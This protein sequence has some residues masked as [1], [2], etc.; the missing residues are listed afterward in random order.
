M[1]KASERKIIQGALELQEKIAIDIM[2]PI[3]KVFMLE[4]STKL[5]YPTLREIYAKGFSRIPIYERTRDNI[6][7]I[8]MARDLILVN[9]DKAM[10]SLKQL[11]SIIIRDVVVVD[12]VDKVEPLLTHFKKGLT[13]IG[14]VTKIV[15]G[16]IGKDPHRQVIGIVTMEDIIEE[17]I[18]DKIED[19]YEIDV[20]NERKLLKEKL[21]LFYTDHQ[22]AK[23]LAGSEIK[24][25]LQFLEHYV[26][27]FQAPHMKRDILHVLIRRSKVV[28]VT[29]DS[30]PFSH[31]MLQ[32]EEINKPR[33]RVINNPG[34]DHYERSKRLQQLKKLKESGKAGA[35][36]DEEAGRTDGAQGE[37]DE[38]K[39]PAT[40]LKMLAES[41]LI[42]RE[43][44]PQSINGNVSQDN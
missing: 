20:R 37:D 23:V 43:K 27:P 2:T 44:N 33:N 21:V 34:Q 9:P 19:E 5:D 32:A 11:S 15:G 4:I 31:N 18:Q 12:D 22:A 39:Q 14:V 30:F 38:E 25:S 1:I 16:Q 6:V 28:I 42:G 40:R 13:H 41:K 10:L 17:L 36:A 7:G 3:D 24:A 29:S 35:D 8:L 26:R